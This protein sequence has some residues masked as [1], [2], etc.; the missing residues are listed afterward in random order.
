MKLFGTS[1]GKK[2]MAHVRFVTFAE[3][4]VEKDIIVESCRKPIELEVV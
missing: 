1:L 2:R 4:K 3:T